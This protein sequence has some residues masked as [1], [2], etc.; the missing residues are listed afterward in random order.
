MRGTV[1]P[2]LRRPARPSAEA[3]RAATIKV[4]QLG[5]ITPACAVDSLIQ[6]GMTPTEAAR[7]IADAVEVKV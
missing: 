6:H 7:A 3:M 1:I 2:L 4:Y 5:G